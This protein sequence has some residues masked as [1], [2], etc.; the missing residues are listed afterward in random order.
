MMI[1]ILLQALPR[2]LRRP[3]IFHQTG[4]NIFVSCENRF[5]GRCLLSLNLRCN[6]RKYRRRITHLDC[7]EGVFLGSKNQANNQH[8]ARQ[9]RS[10]DGGVP[11]ATWNIATCS[12]NPFE[13]SLIAVFHAAIYLLLSSLPFPQGQQAGVLDSGRYYK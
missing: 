2:H 10:M 5:K 9:R 8:E 11:T 12:V 4:L 3:H 6:P 1:L 7:C 13:L